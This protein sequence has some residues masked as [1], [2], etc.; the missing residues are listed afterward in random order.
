MNRRTFWR[1][2]VVLAAVGAA[3]SAGAVRAG[4]DAATPIDVSGT[5]HAGE[6]GQVVWR[7]IKPAGW[8]GTLVLDLDF[9]TWPAAQRD[10]FLQKGYA[11]GGI[12]RTQNETAY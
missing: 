12:Q 8:N 11:I 4:A 9:N 1:F 6:P 7:A 5:F 3:V 10:W 2:A